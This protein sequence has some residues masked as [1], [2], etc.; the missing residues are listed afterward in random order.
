MQLLQTTNGI[1]YEVNKLC[2]E[3][4]LLPISGT[5]TLEQLKEAK[6]ELEARYI[7]Y[8][9]EIHWQRNFKLAK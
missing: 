6:D 4:F 8:F 7:N 3:V 9:M 5:H 2:R 1:Y